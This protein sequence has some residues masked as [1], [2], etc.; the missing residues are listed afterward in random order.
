M[1]PESFSQPSARHLYGRSCL[2][3]C[4]LEYVISYFV[5]TMMSHSGNL[6]VFAL[7]VKRLLNLGAVGVVALILSL[8]ILACNAVRLRDGSAALSDGMRI[9]VVLGGRKGSRGGGG[10]SGDDREVFQIN[11]LSSLGRRRESSQVGD[12]MVVEAIE[13]ID[14]VALC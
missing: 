7:S 4:L 5:Q 10:S 13:A 8:S 9:S 2:S 12:I 11:I 3:M 14:S 6:L 1:K